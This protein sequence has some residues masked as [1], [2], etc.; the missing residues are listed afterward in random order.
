M[1]IS[2]GVEQTPE[3]SA[4]RLRTPD[5]RP[6]RQVLVEVLRRVLT[7]GGDPAAALKEVERRWGELDAAVAPEKR[8]A[9]C[10]KSLSLQ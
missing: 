6:H 9:N 8:L 3:G 7:S 1:T 4:L 2:R 10:R 5:E